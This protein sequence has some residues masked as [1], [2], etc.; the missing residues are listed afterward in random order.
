LEP[1]V[2]FL[3]EISPSSEIIRR[4]VTQDTRFAAAAYDFVWEALDYAMDMKRRADDK[5]A[6]DGISATELL[7]TF[8]TL[9][10]LRFGNGAKHRLNA[11]GIENSED[12][13]EIVFRFC[14]AGY[15]G[16]LPTDRREDFKGGYDLSEAFPEI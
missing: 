7:E 13:G 3:Q 1:A 8:R 14:E 4:I 9:A 11:W 6:S 15:F 2:A 10:L 16:K 12:V 5:R